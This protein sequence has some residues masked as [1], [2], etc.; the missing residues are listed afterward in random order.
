ML[1]DSKDV[2]FETDERG[3]PLV[4]GKGATGE[5]RVGPCFAAAGY[6]LGLHVLLHMFRVCMACFCCAN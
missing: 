1:I 3:H 6:L 5:V 4:L 2:T